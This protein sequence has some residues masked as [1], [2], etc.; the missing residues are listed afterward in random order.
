MAGDCCIAGLG[1]AIPAMKAQV[2]AGMIERVA[3]L[4]HGLGFIMLGQGWSRIMNTLDTSAPLR[5]TTW[6]INSGNRRRVMNSHHTH[7]GEATN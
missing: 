1:G 5:L 7:T 3:N 6:R 4:D 2:L